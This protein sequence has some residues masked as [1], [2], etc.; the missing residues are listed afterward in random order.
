M[1]LLPRPLFWSSIWLSVGILLASGLPETPPWWWGLGFLSVWL[2]WASRR[3]QPSFSPEVGLRLAAVCTVLGGAWCTSIERQARESPDRV[4]VWLR[5]LPPDTPLWLTGHLTD[6]PEPAVGCLSFDIDVTTLQSNPSSA[7]ISSV[8]GRVRLM[9]PMTR[10]EHIREWEQMNLTPGDWLAVKTVLSRRGRYANPGSYSVGDYLDWRG[11]DACGQVIAVT[12]LRPATSS[13][14]SWLKK[15]R[16]H[17]IYQLQQDFDARTA[18][19]LTG[20][21]LGSE[22]FLDATWAESFRQSGTFHLLV[23]SGSHFALVAGLLVWVLARFGTHRWLTALTV[24]SAAWSYALLVGLNPPVWRAVVAVSIWQLVGLWYRRPHWLNVL[25]A[26]ACVLLVTQPSNLFAASFQLT[27]GAVLALVGV[28][29]PLYSRLQSIGAWRPKRTTPYPPH[30]P[31]FVRRLAEAIFWQP[32]QVQA[33]MRG[34]PVT[35][36]LDKSRW[37][38]RLERFGFGNYNLQTLLRWTFGLLLASACVQFVLL[39]LN[40]F[41]FNRITLGGGLA[42]L[43][44]ELVMSVVLLSTLGYFALLAVFP[45]GAAL[46]KWLVVE[47][48]H[49]LVWIAEVGSQLGN[50]R[51]PHWEG[52]GLTLYGGF[53]LGC[54]LLTVALERWQPLFPR[55]DGRHKTRLV[56]LGTVLC[57]G[58]GWLSVA[59]PRAWRMPPA[60]WLRVTFLDVGQGDCIL[61]E[62]PTGETILVDGGGQSF[63]GGYPQLDGFRDDRPD[64]GE[65]VIAR[66]LWARGIRRLDAVVAT[67]PDTDHIGGLIPLVTNVAIGQVWHGPARVDK[68]VFRQLIQALKRRDIPYQSVSDGWRLQLGNVH[69]KFLWPPAEAAPTGTNNDSLVLRVEY[70]RRAFLLT[71]DIEAAAERQ[72]VA[73][74]AALACDVVKAPHHGSRSSSLVE[75]IQSTRAV[76][77]VFSAPRQSPFGHPHPEVLHRYATLLPQAGQWHTGRDGAVTFETN[78]DLLHVESYAGRGGA[79]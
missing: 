61:L 13:S 53:A 48:V 57:V 54:V 35:Y 46:I 36:R 55:H 24:L 45:P 74:H 60:G 8:C 71:S 79:W 18:G 65:R 10:P 14:G 25:G 51:V 23:I 43:V 63:D 37:A 21:V 32:A 58:F 78:G 76:H 9:L 6:W 69:L 56:V 49:C 5:T 34:E 12:R 41:Y 66:C 17:A 39:P 70:G 31:H 73:Q 19:L 33:Q 16:L 7:P 52:W 1:R 15:L 62:F 27:F 2:L 29:A 67:H 4:R 75:F 26:C 47:S 30:V 3:R 72:L 68:P 64:I 40:L 42:T 22:R 77:V 38:E 59:P 50:W 44:A 11:Y 28:A 20:I